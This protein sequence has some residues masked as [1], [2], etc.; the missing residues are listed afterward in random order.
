[1]SA[2]TN[3]LAAINALFSADQEKGNNKFK[4][5]FLQTAWDELATAKEDTGADSFTT[6]Q[7]ALATTAQSQIKF[8]ME[9]QDN[10]MN[11]STCLALDEKRGVEYAHVTKALAT[12]QELHALAYEVA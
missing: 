11:G 5:A 3:A 6:A 9:M 4:R 2:K 8:A 1:M 10:V 12:V 7:A